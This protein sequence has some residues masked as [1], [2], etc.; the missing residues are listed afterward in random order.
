MRNHPF[1]HQ[2]NTAILSASYNIGK[3]ASG[4]MKKTY[5]FYFPCFSRSNG[6]RVMMILSEKLIKAGYSVLYYVPDKTNWPKHIP[7]INILT[8]EMK[9]NAIVV[10]PEVIAG[11]PLRIRNVARLVLFYPGLNGG[12]KKFHHSEMVFTYL[13]EFFPDADVLTI[14]WI[15]ENLFNN[16]G[17]ERSQD[18]CFVHKGGRWK[19][20]PE[21]RDLPTITMD[22]PKTREELADLLKH[23]RTVYSF[24]SN[25]AVICEAHSCGANVLIVT[26]TGYSKPSN[27]YEQIV[28]D[29][30]RQ[31]TNFIER[32]QSNN[33]KGRIQ[34]RYLFAYWAYAAWRFWIKPCF[35]KH[36]H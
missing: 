10:Y 7:T 36:K 8:R 19:D 24:D 29:F 9:S 33:Y 27:I 3:K 21:L 2:N 28:K 13:P 25:S 23:A 17:Y 16:P 32:T 26:K 20:P 12:M 11:N 6:V 5:I 14:P 35:I 30:P 1:Q 15:D 34:S 22:W 18:Y 4:Q 31:F